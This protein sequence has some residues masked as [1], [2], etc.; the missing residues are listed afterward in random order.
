MCLLHD[1]LCISVACAVMLCL[2]VCLSYFLSKRIN[3]TSKFVDHQVATPLSTKRHGSVAT[4][5]PLMKA[6]N[7]G[8]VDKN[9][10]SRPTSAFIG[11]THTAAS[12]CGK[13]RHSSRRNLL[14]VG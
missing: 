9:H 2:S 4:G 11:A 10:D 6:S 8:G 1:V 7:A 14:F 13:L 3:V 12:D 5:T